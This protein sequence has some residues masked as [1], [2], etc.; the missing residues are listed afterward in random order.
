MPLLF[1][2]GSNCN[3]ER[4][5]APERLGGAATRSTRAET[6][7]EYDLSFEVWSQGN[8]CAASNLIPAHGTSRHAWG[9]LYDVSA[10]RIRGRHR[11]DGK[12]TMEEIE[13]KLYEEKAIR[14]RENAGAEV[15][16]TTF[17]VKPDARR[18]GLWT[19]AEYVRH[20]IYGLRAHDVPEEYVQRVIDIAT[21]TNQRATARAGQEIR[22]IAELRR[23]FWNS[24]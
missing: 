2:Y 8:G 1:Q 11:P 7:D 18:Q 9:V 4:L 14:I 13:G 16:A 10:E 12:K 3:A 21:E 15:E 20:I 19:S 23:N 6:V 17:T 24:P 5:N 22:L